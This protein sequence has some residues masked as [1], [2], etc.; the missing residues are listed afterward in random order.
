MKNIETY[1]KVLIGVLSIAI[2][3][4]AGY[5]YHMKTQEKSVVERLINRYGTAHIDGHQWAGMTVDANG[6]SFIDYT[7]VRRTGD[8]ARV[9]VLRDLTKP[10]T[11]ANGT[12][13]LSDRAVMEFK[14]GERAVRILSTAHYRLAMG[15]GDITHKDDNASAWMLIVPNTP[16]DIAC[17]VACQEPAPGGLTF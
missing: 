2:L 15:N 17:M 9:W 6:S 7:A 5:F 3:A 4:G 13:M 11:T 14:C 8:L 1:L 10:Q 16:A 12:T